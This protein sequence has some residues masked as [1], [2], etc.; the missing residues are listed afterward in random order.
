MTINNN[1]EYGFSFDDYSTDKMYENETTFKYKGKTYY[2][3]S[4]GGGGEHAVSETEIKLVT[5]NVVLTLNE[6]SELV[7]KSANP[8]EGILKVG[9][10]FAP[11]N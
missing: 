2:Q 5:D 4:G 9:S 11:A 6:K 1:G 10:V 3:C 7:V 8:D